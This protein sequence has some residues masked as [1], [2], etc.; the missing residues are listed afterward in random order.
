MMEQFL[1]GFA[2]GL[3]IGEAIMIFGIRSLLLQR[4]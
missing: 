3:M 4:R 1:V 2:A